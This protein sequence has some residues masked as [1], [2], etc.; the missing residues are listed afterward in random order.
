METINR[1]KHNLEIMQ[2]IIEG[3]KW[4][5]DKCRNYLYRAHLVNP[6]LK[7]QT[8][9]VSVPDSFDFDACYFLKVNNFSETGI[10]T[11]YE[12][13]NENLQKLQK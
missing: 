6:E 7:L 5:A 12:R 8:G 13:I 9:T 3:L 10:K 1:I 2:R 4:E 11:A